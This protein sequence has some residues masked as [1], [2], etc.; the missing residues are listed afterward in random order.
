MQTPSQELANFLTFI[1]PHSGVQPDKLAALA[2]IYLLDVL[3]S[4]DVLHFN[5]DHQRF[6]VKK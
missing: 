6:E 3:E 5:Y 4:I 2:N 1:L